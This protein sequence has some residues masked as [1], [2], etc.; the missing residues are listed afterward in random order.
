MCPDQLSPHALM[1][2]H[3]TVTRFNVLSHIVVT[4]FSFIRLHGGQSVGR[5]LYHQ[6][7]IT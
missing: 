5:S 7:I 6:G 1:K 3:E 2:S 4:L